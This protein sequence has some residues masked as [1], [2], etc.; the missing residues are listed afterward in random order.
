MN[1]EKSLVYLFVE[2][3]VFIGKFYIK[4]LLARQEK[5]SGAN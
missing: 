1:Y 5:G 4:A 2:S 3:S